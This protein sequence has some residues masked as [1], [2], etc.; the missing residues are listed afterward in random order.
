MPKICYVSQSFYP[1]TGGVSDY[2]LDLGKRLVKEGYEVHEITLST[3]E[4][5][6]FEVVEGINV[7][8][9]YRKGSAD[10]ISEYGIFKE[11][12][13]KVSHGE[14]VS[15]DA[16]SRREKF[17]YRKYLRLNEE[18]L[19]E[20]KQ[21][22]D[23]EHFD[24][25]HVHDFQFL[26]LGGMM[27]EEG[28]KCPMVFTW[29][30][31]FLKDMPEEWKDFF[32]EYMNDYDYCVLSTDEYVEAAVDA[33]LDKDKIVRIMPFIDSAR[34]SAG[35]AKEFRQ[36]FRLD[37]AGD[38]TITQSTTTRDDALSWLYYVLYGQKPA[39]T[40][41][42]DGPPVIMC[43]SRMDPRKGHATLIGAMPYVLEEF[44]YAKAVFVGNGSMTGKIIASKT[45]GG[46]RQK[47]EELVTQRNLKHSVIF[48][49]Y[50]PDSELK[51]A[52]ASSFV[53]VQ[54]S[55]MEGFGLTVTEAMMFGKPVVGSR[56]GGIKYQIV[57]GETGY[58]FDPGNYKQ[59][60]DRILN[61]LR[62]PPKAAEMGRKGQ[63]RAMEMFDVSRGLKEYLRL[64]EKAL[65]G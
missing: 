41:F 18:A 16:L 17:G 29:H 39:E 8:R 7:H 2:L 46:Y 51:N 49:G 37:W 45:R 56:V 3:P 4:T 26:P 23:E 43:V 65:S 20:I 59:L 60:A 48:T 34:F 62:D 54:P 47:L 1:Y 40:P 28:I 21:L 11:N 14:R 58:L 57:D 36:K 15:S 64:Y 19:K 32:T 38:A 30:V 61:L 25:I 12:I 13:L 33:G 63:A 42:Y 55:I 44:P 27:R 10:T 24:I 9:F 5:L 52:F 35:D 31:P 22:N 53:V 50:V 6:R